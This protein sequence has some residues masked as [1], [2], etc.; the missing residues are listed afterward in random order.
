MEQDA[1]KEQL[2]PLNEAVQLRLEDATNMGFDEDILNQDLQPDICTPNV[3][4]E[5]RIN[6]KDVHVTNSQ[7][8]GANIKVT[9]T[10]SMRVHYAVKLVLSTMKPKLT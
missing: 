9:A 8:L 5:Q 7:F 10:Q 1:I 2:Q 3:S 4:L 6:K